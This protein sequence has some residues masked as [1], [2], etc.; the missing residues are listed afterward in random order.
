MAQKV[1]GSNLGVEGLCD[2]GEGHL[3]GIE[4][5]VPWVWPLVKDLMLLTVILMCI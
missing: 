3:F 2:L 4:F 5:M 1:R